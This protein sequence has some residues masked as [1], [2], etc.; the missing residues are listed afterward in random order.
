M[1]ATPLL[2]R[3]TEVRALRL[4]KKAGGPSKAFIALWNKVQANAIDFA[5]E[6]P[7]VKQYLDGHRYAVVGGELRP[8]R[9]D[10]RGKFPPRIGEVGIYDYD[11]DVLMIAVVDLRKRT[12]LDLEERRGIQPPLSKSE[13]QEAKA[14]VLASSSYRR[15]AK[16]RSLHV[17]GFVARV[18]FLPEHPSYGHRVFTL[19]FWS[20]GRRNPRKLQDAVVDLSNRQVLEEDDHDDAIMTRLLHDRHEHAGEGN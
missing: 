2:S 7:R 13:L 15:L 19:A 14:I 20:G 16:E 8:V 4:L 5:L 6:Q 10:G 12:L 18:S 11:R 3:E 17:E 1:K 9:G